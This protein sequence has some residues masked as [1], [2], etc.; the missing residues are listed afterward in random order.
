MI[1]EPARL[2]GC[3]SASFVDAFSTGREA[4][5]DGVRLVSGYVVEGRTRSG[6]PVVHLDKVVDRPLGAWMTDLN[7]LREASDIHWNEQSGCW[8]ITRAGH[9]REIYQNPAVFTND[10]ITPGDPDPAYRWI[11]SNVNPPRHVE[12][13]QILN[14]A[15]GPGPVARIA[16]KAREYCRMAIEGVA[17]RGRCDVVADVAGVFPT[18]VFLELVD[19]PWEHAPQFVAWTETIFDGYFRSAG[20]ADAMAA[21][22]RYFA[23]LIEDRRRAPRDPATDF[24]S[25]L[26]ASEVGGVPISDED[27][28]NIFGQLVLAGLDTVKSALSYSLMHLATH[29]DDRRRVVEDSSM[30][31]AAVEELLRAYPLVMQGRKLSRDVDFHGVRM[32]AGEMVMFVAPAIMHDPAAFDR[33]DDVV[34]DRSRNNHLA[35]GGGPHRCLGSHLARMELVVGLEEWHRAIPD[36]RLGCPVDEII[37]RGG[38]LSLRALPLRWD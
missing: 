1:L 22:R 24:A 11:P 30:L 5:P 27:V 16:D 4:R 29:D 9:A 31:P 20:A 2:G 8:L 18:R 14:H 25:H 13:R 3:Q 12:Y 23:D 28:L 33:A 35:F 32:R 10:S 7:D 26:L 19:L 37:E 36:Y 34:L 15:F 17:D 6:C 21:I 38:Q